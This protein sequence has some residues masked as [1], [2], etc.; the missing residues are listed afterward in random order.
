MYQR[1]LNLQLF[2]TKKPA[3]AGSFSYAVLVLIYVS[4]IL[5]SSF[6][7]LRHRNNKHSNRIS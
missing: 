1:A 4:K 6:P 3:P 2:T 7:V 5:S